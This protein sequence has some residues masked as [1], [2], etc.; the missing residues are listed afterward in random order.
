[1]RR[2]V[3]L[4]ILFVVPG[5]GSLA[6]D[7]TRVLKTFDFEE[8]PLGN[9]E[10]L[11]MRWVKVRGPGLPH[12]VNGQLATDRHR[13]GGH[14]FRFDLNGGGLIYRYGPGLIKVQRW[15]HYRIEGWCQ[16]TVLPNAR[17]R[18]TAYFADIDGRTLPDT[19]RHSE[20]YAAKTEG[21][22]WKQ[23]S[24]ELSAD[25]ERAESLVIELELLQPMHY[26]TS[27]LGERALFDQDI[28][29]SAWWDDVT[30]SQV[31]QVALRTDRPANIFRRDE[32]P[33]ISAL[34]HDRF[35]DDLT[36]QLSVRDADGKEVYQRTGTPDVTTGGRQD[37]QRWRMTL[38]LPPLPP[39]YYEASLAMSSQT[40]PLI[41][42]SLHFV[43]LADG[44]K[45]P[46]PDARFGFVATDLPFDSW[47]ELP[48]ILPMFSA[49]RVKLAIW[50][51]RGGVETSDEAS[52][53]RLLARFQ[54]RGITP[55]ACLLGPPPMLA[56]KLGGP[57]WLPLLKASEQDW[58]PELA[59]LV[60]RHANH[61]ERW[62]LGTD[63]SDAFVTD[64][65]MR[66]VYRLVYQQFARLME[67]PELAMPWSAWY[68]LPPDL[69]AGA[70]L[71]V[72][73]AILPSQLPLYIQD[74]AGHKRNDISLTF[75][76]LDRSRYGRDVQLRDLAQRVV[77]AL[78]AGAP[79]IDL[80]LP[81]SVSRDEDGVTLQPDELFTVIRTLFT[82]LSGAEFKGKVTLAEGIEAF[83]FDRD[84]QG[85][86]ALWDRGDRAGMKD[87]AVNLGERP[88]SIDL[89]GNISPLL[90]RPGN[91]AGRVALRVG[92]MP[93][94]LVGI[95]AQQAQLRASVAIDRPLLESSFRPHERRIRFVN[96]YKQAITG[97]LKL[98]G[99][100]GW[101][102]NP[103]T[104]NFSLNPGDT[105]D[106]PVT[107]Q[108]PYNS[109]AGPKTLAC[110]F[111]IEGEQDADFM[112]PLMLRLGLTDVGMQTLAVRDG[113]NLVVQ[114][115]ITNYGDKPINY[116]A[117]ALCPGQAR[118]E[119]LVTDLQPAATTIKRF[120]FTNLEFS[121]PA[122]VRVGLK[123]LEGARILND[124][125]EVR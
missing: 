16:T 54:E 55:T 123:E 116:T 40:K 121:K 43:V 33:R 2:A 4:L 88:E 61:L 95:D 108:F 1:M 114:Q 111:H 14:S 85:I 27:K 38:E 115:M 21:E 18:I 9:E 39:G 53:D 104:F 58:Q 23:L 105:F 84:G 92:P 47:D 101:T 10:E 44:G 17:A 28:R 100:T 31:P 113:R 96:P 82:T 90:R 118:Q 15:A 125:I 65:R 76:L 25:S 93:M 67:K 80:P 77:Y 34:I 51:E 26:A 3:A 124:Q 83:L 62:Q 89:F 109:F 12:Y 59:Y 98:S 42:Q 72:P 48:R 5:A 63:E 20:L 110:D 79:R 56:D 107:I 86:L 74:L 35:T 91:R 52:F 29:G 75:E 45:S 119:R 36:A 87:L 66:E 22:T 71:A 73:T 60:S 8:R 103:P 13:S 11:P 57:G 81:L 78:A 7:L 69:S 19:V 102:L 6:A 112:V 30:V 46:S 70:A 99:P 97:V 32:P 117:F 49:A 41:S 94:F 37:D 120:R 68:E 50:S 106:R 64:S 122:T 24:V